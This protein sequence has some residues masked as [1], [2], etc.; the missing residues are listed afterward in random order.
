MKTSKK[1][2]AAQG[3]L[4]K[5]YALGLICGGITK[6]QLAE[7]VARMIKGGILH[8]EVEIKTEGK[9]TWIFRKRSKS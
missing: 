3:E 2:E 9:Q 5:L 1:L 7:S 6:S 8:A 4:M